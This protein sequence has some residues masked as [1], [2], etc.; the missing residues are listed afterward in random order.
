M[1]VHVTMVGAG[2]ALHEEISMNRSFCI[3]CF[4]LLGFTNCSAAKIRHYYIA[5]EDVLWDFAPSNHDLIGSRELPVKEQVIG[6]K[7]KKTRYVEYTDSSFSKRKPQ[8]AWLGI[9]G[10]VIRAEV[11]DTV[12]VHFLNRSSTPHNIHPH[13]L[14]YDKASEGSLYI[15]PGAGA[16]IPAGGHFQYR[17]LADAD[18]GPALG[19][20]SSVIWMYHPHD[21]EPVE[22]NAGLIGPIIVTARGKVKPS[23]VPQDV[24]R[25]F[26]TLFMIFDQLQGKPEG[27]FYSINGYIFGNLPGLVMTKGEHVRW[28]L[29]G[30][31]DENDIHTP[32]WH[33]KTVRQGNHRT[34]VIELLPAS[35]VTTNMV[36][37]NVGTWLFHCQVAEHIENGMMA[38]FTI[39]E[40]KRACPVTLEPDFWSVPE[41]FRVRVRNNGTKK[42]ASVHLRAEYMALTTN[43]IRGFADE[44]KW[45]TS[46]LPDQEHTLELQDYFRQKGLVGYF[47]DESIIGWA[48]YPTRIEYVDGTAW[49]QRDRA[50]CFAVSWRPGAHSSLEILPPLQP[51]TELPEDYP[52]P[53]VVVPAPS[54]RQPLG[55][56]VRKP[57]V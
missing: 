7:W 39:H 33:G 27:L 18:S 55:T 4:I 11:G 40:P 51:D 16:R 20:D 13:G 41:K 45:A 53:R 17:W 25:E 56:P 44:W 37:D 42:I 26:V 49:V 57:P 34:D 12:V 31:G 6:T 30:M 1:S 36:A 21:D 48:V 46:I 2:I 29:M 9:L 10:P 19:D 50:E 43:N 35:M 14:R 24:D 15:P 8:P 54:R 47:N 22:T 23:G 32:H 5:A 3:V 38:T 28:Y 52:A